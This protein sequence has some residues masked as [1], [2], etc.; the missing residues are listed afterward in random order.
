MFYGA[1]KPEQG[2]ILWYKKDI[3]I[4]YLKQNSFYSQR[5]WNGN[6]INIRN[7]EYIKD[8]IEISSYLG[9]RKIDPME[10]E[11]LSSLS[12]G[13][14]MNLALANIWSRNPDFLILDEPTNRIDYQ[15]MN[16][17]IEELKKY[18]GTENVN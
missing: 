13:E 11:R 12:G 3:E 14:K 8:L 18:K 1:L 9:M 17:L 7:E 10:G 16:W 15:G 5:T 6:E 2:S 4:G